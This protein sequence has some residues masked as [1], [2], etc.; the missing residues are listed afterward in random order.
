MTQK[1]PLNK[2]FN[3]SINLYFPIFFDESQ[4][5]TLSSVFFDCDSS[6]FLHS[7]KNNP[8]VLKD[9]LKYVLYSYL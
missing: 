1:E 2:E 5:I 3:P 9:N 6:N 8:E 7:N 4:Y